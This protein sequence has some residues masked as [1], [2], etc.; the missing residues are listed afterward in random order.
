MNV[1]RYGKYNGREDLESAPGFFVLG[2]CRRVCWVCFQELRCAFLMP[3]VFHGSRV[4]AEAQ[5]AMTRYRNRLV[6]VALL[7]R[8]SITVGA[9]STQTSQAEHKAGIASQA[10]ENV[11]TPE[12]TTPA[13]VL[14][15]KS[16]AELVLV[17]VGVRHPKS[18][19]RRW[20]SPVPDST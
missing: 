13:V 18:N 17:P 2:G 11:S 10:D 19:L 9:Q 15:F 14:T 4:L 16:R 20:S 7:I 8:F 6:F 5:C 12:I 3:C 1:Y